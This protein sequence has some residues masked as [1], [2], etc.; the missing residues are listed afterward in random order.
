MKLA[1]PTRASRANHLARRLDEG[2]TE[3]NQLRLLENGEEFFP[4]VFAAIE[5]A[6]HEVLIETFILFEDKVGLALHDVLLRAAQRGVRINVTVDGFGSPALSTQF[7][8]SLTDAGVR[9]HVFDPPPKLSRRL[10]LFRRLH[11]K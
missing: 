5:A 11:R 4:A 3:G 1:P 8:S 10:G 9:L 7:V 6:Q 2:W